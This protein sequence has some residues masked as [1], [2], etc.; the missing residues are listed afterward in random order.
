MQ[1]GTNVKLF[2]LILYATCH[3]SWYLVWH[4]CYIL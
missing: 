2:L 3:I 4:G 1:Q